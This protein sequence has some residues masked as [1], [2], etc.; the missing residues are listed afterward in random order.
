[1]ESTN[2]ISR[3]ATLSHALKGAALITFGAVLTMPSS[4]LAGKGNLGTAGKDGRVLEGNSSAAFSS[5]GKRLAALSGNPPGIKVWDCESG[6]MVLNFGAPSPL[7]GR[8]G[9]DLVTFSHV[10]FTSDNERLITAGLFP[11]HGLAMWDA[12]SGQMLKTFG[13][14]L[15]SLG[16]APQPWMPKVNSQL[17]FLRLTLSQDGERLYA[18]AYDCGR[19]NIP[20]AAGCWNATEGELEFSLHETSGTLRSLVISPDGKHLAA[21]LQPDPLARMAAMRSQFS[22]ADGRPPA[23]LQASGMALAS[24][25]RSQRSQETGI[26]VWDG[27]SGQRKHL[28]AFSGLPRAFSPD[29]KQLVCFAGGQAGGPAELRLWDMES[30]KESASIPLADVKARSCGQILFSPDGRTIALV[31]NGRQVSLRESSTGKLLHSLD[32]A[33]AVGHLAF[34]PDGKMLAAGCGDPNE[35]FGSAGDVKLWK[36]GDGKLVRHFKGQRGTVSEVRFSP[37][38]KR[39]LSLN[40]VSMMLWNVPTD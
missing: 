40:G 25:I 21:L 18:A 8:S 19:F 14:N 23:D 22:R 17:R 29:G 28:L 30:G 11:G 1:M 37:D 2:I 36:V 34:S 27:V 20:G 15:L 12:N 9:R 16:P 24:E 3:V 4:A 39:L 32:S 5:D 38:G 35:I 31:L 6:K 10:V 7:P 26:A 13:T 33:T